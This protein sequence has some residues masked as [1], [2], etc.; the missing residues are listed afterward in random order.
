MIVEIRLDSECFSY[1]RDAC[2]EQSIY[3]LDQCIKYKDKSPDYAIKCDNESNKYQQ[4]Y[5]FFYDLWRC[6]RNL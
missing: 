3:Y 2:N 5:K 4:L 6:Y 1:L